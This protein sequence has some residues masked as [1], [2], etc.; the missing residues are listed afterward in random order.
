MIR[1]QPLRTWL[2]RLGWGGI[3]LYLAPSLGQVVFAHG[4]FPLDVP[5]WVESWALLGLLLILAASALGFL[6]RGWGNLLPFL[7]TGL[8]VIPGLLAAMGVAAF[9][10][11]PFA[12]LS[13]ATLPD[14]RVILYGTEP[15]FTDTVYGIWQ[16]YRLFVWRHPV[17]EALSYSEDGTFTEGAGLVLTP[18]GTRLLVRRQGVWTD[19]LLV[20]RPLMLCP[21]VRRG[22]PAVAEQYAARN[23][24]IEALTGLRASE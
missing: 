19:C 16:D 20:G 5:G 3:V 10:A 18:D 1:V 8:L 15:V 23:K 14:G 17:S 11:K 13:R 4:R 24:E 7:G 2:R 22:S 6:I 21:G 12:E 9:I